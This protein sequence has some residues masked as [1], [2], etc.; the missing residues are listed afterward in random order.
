MGRRL[1]CPGPGLRSQ[2]EQLNLQL[3]RQ[4]TEGQRLQQE[5]A[6]EQKVRASLETALAQATA[7]L[8]DIVQVN[9]KWV[10]VG[11]GRWSQGQKLLGDNWA[12]GD[13]NWAIGGGQ[14][15]RPAYSL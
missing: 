2:R 11:G 14:A 3:E 10:K 1:T 6:E 7:F 15:R 9:R 12:I 8:Q 4:Q 13:D 5:L